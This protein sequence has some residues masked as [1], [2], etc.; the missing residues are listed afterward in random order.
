MVE[1]ASD[2]SIEDHEFKMFMQRSNAYNEI[3]QQ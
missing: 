2:H 3:K 1:A